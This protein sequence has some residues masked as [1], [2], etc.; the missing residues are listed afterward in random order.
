MR[1]RGARRARPRLLLLPRPLDARAVPRAARVARD[2]HHV[3]KRS[4]RPS[5]PSR[6]SSVPQP[7]HPTIYCF[8]QGAPDRALASVAQRGDG[9]GISRAAA[10]ARARRGSTARRARP[11]RRSARAAAWACTA[12]PA[13]PRR[14]RSTRA[15]TRSARRPTRRSTRSAR[16]AARRPTPRA[17]PVTMATRPSHKP[18]IF[19]PFFLMWCGHRPYCWS[20]TEMIFEEISSTVIGNVSA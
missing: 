8:S 18:D 11:R 20:R 17:A 13:R 6:P 19:F 5:R 10:T 14:R 7:R 15:T 2:D 9:A 16:R 4:R 1:E 12:R 3:A